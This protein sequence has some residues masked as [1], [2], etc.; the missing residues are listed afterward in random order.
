MAATCRPVPAYN[1][2]FSPR[3]KD[4]SEERRE[5]IGE[6]RRDKLL[7]MKIKKIGACVAMAL[8]ALS[9][10]GSA[11]ARANSDDSD[12][13]GQVRVDV[14]V[15][16]TEAG[17]KVTHPTPDKPAFYLPISVGYK[18]FGYAHNFQRPP[19]N[20]WDIQ[21]ALAI[22]LYNQGYQLLTKQGHPSL[23]LVFW[24]G[25]MAPEDVDMD[26][27]SGPVDRPGSLEAPGWYWGSGQGAPT[28]PGPNFI[29]SSGVF[30]SFSM[31]SKVANQD[32]ILSMVAGET[33]NDHQKFLDPRLENIEQLL[34]QPRYYI[35]VSAFDFQS[36]LH[37]K[38][39]LLW[40]A[41]VSTELWGHYFDQ[42]VGTL[43]STAGPMFGRSTSAPHF[44]TES[45]TPLGR[46]VIGTP[47][48]KDYSVMPATG[49]N[50]QPSP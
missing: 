29:G 23:V 38:P 12:A 45:I 42:V 50:P 44:S 21:H 7:T 20:E 30:P 9:P 2:D 46:V 13:S 33:V 36:W 8:V 48:V 26:N 4:L 35:L 32:T 41:H 22:A 39:V 6:R 49:K 17:H 40:R 27:P 3:P 15:D 34:D 24:W 47:V 10:I 43:I 5:E 16:M 25:Y 19:P 37:H 18:T 28:P 1:D 11:F 14:V 31:L